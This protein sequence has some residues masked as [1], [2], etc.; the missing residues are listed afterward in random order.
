MT[1]NHKAMASTAADTITL[2]DQQRQNWSSAAA[3]WSR[4]DALLRKGA[5]PVSKR[6]LDLSTIVAGSS[7]LD[8]ASGTGEPALSAAHRVGSS[9][10]VTGIDLADAMLA[11]ARKKAAA[12]SL[13]NIQFHCMD[14]ENMDFAASSFDAITI[15]WG[16]MFMPEPQA[17]L[18]AAHNTLKQHGRI[19]MACWASPEKNP[20][21]SLLL[22]NLSNYM[23]LPATAPG[24]PGIFAFAD[25]ERLRA[26]LHSAGFQNIKLEEMQINVLEVENGQAYWQAISDLAAPVMALVRQLDDASRSNYID[27]VIK[28][29]D[30][31]KQGETLRMKGTTW[32][33]SADK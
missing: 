19:C 2:K 7:L 21:V 17:C 30:A 3:G 14:A 26:A 25:P 5:A 10:R 8:I 1:T 32:I 9:G 22:N 23:D 6:M 20:F 4:R 16:L 12:A 11:I 27:D 31:M 13:N 15:R 24:T 28:A 33:A 29:A 18:S